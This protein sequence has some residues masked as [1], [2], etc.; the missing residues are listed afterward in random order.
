[1]PENTIEIIPE[2]AEPIDGGDAPDYEWLL[3][4]DAHL[5]CFIL[6]HYAVGAT[7]IDGKILVEN[8]DKIFDWIKDGAVPR[9]KRKTNLTVVPPAERN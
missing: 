3:Q 6:K 9:A 1:M 2:S 5:R 4:N 8:M 7:E